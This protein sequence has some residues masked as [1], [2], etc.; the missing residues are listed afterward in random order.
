MGLVAA[1]RDVLAPLLL[2]ACLLPPAT[3]VDPA[4]APPATAVPADPAT[5]Y[6]AHRTAGGHD[7]RFLTR[8]T[9]GRGLVTEVFGDLTGARAVAVVVGGVGTDL[10]TFDRGTLRAG[11][12]ALAASAPEAAVVAW[13]DYVSPG[14]L[15]LAAAGPALARTGGDRLRVLLDSLREHGSAQRVVLVCHSYGSAV[16]AAALADGHDHGVGDVVDLASAGVLDGRLAPGVDRY[17]ALGEAD[18][19]RFVPHVRLGGLGLGRDP[20]STPGAHR[21]PVPA[22]GDHDDYLVPGSPTLTAVAGLLSA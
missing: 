9:T 14:G 21:L 22:D 3:P 2:V 10:A 20:A 11:A 4:G 18:P 12:A 5:A 17:V 15:G 16:C 1:C 8:D 19:I 13:A 6:A 7:R